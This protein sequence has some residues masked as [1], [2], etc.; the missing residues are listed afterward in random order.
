[1]AGLRSEP[2]L[3]NKKCELKLTVIIFV[4]KFICLLKT[5]YTVQYIQKC[6]CFTRGGFG[7]RNA[8][9]GLYYRL[10]MP[11]G[12]SRIA[13]YVND[14]ATPATPA[15]TNHILQPTVTANSIRVRWAQ[16]NPLPE[17][18][19]G[20]DAVAAINDFQAPDL[21]TTSGIFNWCI[22]TFVRRQ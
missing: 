7:V 2:L 4:R 8:L 5:S 13:A 17:R 16:L 1:M 14:P 19:Y 10:T 12:V 9:T 15:V 3:S 6:G 20:Y 21:S 22:N 18:P 11:T